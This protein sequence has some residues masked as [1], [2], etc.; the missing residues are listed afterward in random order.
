MLEDTTMQR[1]DYILRNI[2]LMG[3][4]LARVRRMLIEGKNSEAAEEI[5]RVSRDGGLDLPLLMGLDSESIAQ[6][7]LTGGEIDRPKS[8]FFA[9][10]LH[11]EWRR[12]VA[13]GSAK[14][15]PHCAQR[16]LMLYGLA[17]HGIVVDDETKERVASLE[18]Y[19]ELCERSTTDITT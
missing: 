10:I 6:L 5:N 18:D 4:A 1:E 13:V 11:L 14:T 9:E 8:A 15:A 12:R 16:A 7:L 2:A 19:L 17:Y 3:R